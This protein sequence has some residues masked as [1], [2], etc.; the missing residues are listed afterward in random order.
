MSELSPFDI[1]TPEAVVLDL[2]PAGLASRILAKGVDLL[3]Q[4]FAAFG[5]LLLATLLSEE[6]GDMGTV[7]TVVLALG[8]FL[9]ILFLPALIETLWNGRSPGKALLG[10][11]VV[12]DEGGPVAFRHAIVRGLLQVVEL[13]LGAAL[14]AALASRRSKRLG[15]L[16]AGTFVIKERGAGTAVVPTVFYPPHG[17]DG[18][19]TALDVG[20]LGSDQFLL[21]RNFLMRVG[22][23]DPAARSQLG[24]RLA[25][26]LRERISPPPPPQLHPEAYLICVASAYQLR[27]GGLPGWAPNGSGAAR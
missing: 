4:G 22:E 14:V 9:V 11:R 8:L 17:F 2:R 10:I 18:Y 7:S 27:N 3:L 1:V 23:L 25:D 15:D 5:V 24:L 20:S 6:D 19:V 26:A 21:V 13:P 16:A 12:T